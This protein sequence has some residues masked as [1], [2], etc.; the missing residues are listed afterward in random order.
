[1][2]NKKKAKKSAFGVECR[3]FY[4]L[5]VSN[6]V[7]CCRRSVL[8]ASGADYWML[9][10]GCSLCSLEVVGRGVERSVFGGYGWWVLRVACRVFKVRCVYSR[11]CFGGG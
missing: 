6:G 5:S 10:A 4:A 7:P 1:M 11:W 2:A 3:V 9:G 8:I